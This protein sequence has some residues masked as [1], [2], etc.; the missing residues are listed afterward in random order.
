MGEGEALD[1][2]I[3]QV[4]TVWLGHVKLRLPRL[5]LL[6]VVP[7]LPSSVS[8]TKVPEPADIRNLG[9]SPLVEL[10]S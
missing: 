8:A 4:P 9:F 3:A 5:S 1:F 2:R 6:T 7:S 10:G